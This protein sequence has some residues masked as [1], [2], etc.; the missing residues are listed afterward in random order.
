M[1]HDRH[2]SYRTDVGAFAAHVAACDYLEPCLLCSINI[3]WDEFKLHYFFLDRMTP[4]LY[5]KCFGELRLSWN[6]KYEHVY[7]RE[8]LTVIIHCNEM[9]EC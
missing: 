3:V 8:V 9:R 2:Q 1:S 6:G 5:T 4:S 7:A